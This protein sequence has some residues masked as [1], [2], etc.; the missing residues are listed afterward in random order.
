MAYNPGTSLPEKYARNL[1]ICDYSAGSN[2]GVHACRAE[3]NGAGF[4]MKNAE[5]FVWGITATDVTFGYD[6]KAYVCDYGGGWG[7]SGKGSVI[8]ISEPASLKNPSVD[9]TRKLVADGIGKLETK[10]LLELLKH[11]DM[12][13][14]QHA[15]FELAKR[16]KVG[17]AALTEA[18]NTPGHTLSRVH[19]IWG[20]G[21]LGKTEPA[22]LKTVVAL[23]DDADSRVREQSIKVLSDAKYA[24]AME[25]LLALLKDKNPRVQSFAAIALGKLKCRSDIS[26]LIEILRAND[27]KDAFLRHAAIM[28]LAGS[29]DAAALQSYITDASKAVRLGVLLAYRKMGEARAAEFLRDADP[30]IYAETL[31]AIYEEPIL[32]AM[33]RLAAEINRVVA[34]PD[35]FKGLTPLLYGRILNAA[36][37]YGGADFAPAIARLASIPGIPESVR[38]SALEMLERWDDPTFVDPISGLPRPVAKRAKLAPNAEMREAI[39]KILTENG[40][41]AAKAADMALAFGVELT[42]AM[43]LSFAKNDKRGDAIRISAMQQ[44]LQHKNGELAALLPKIVAE[45]KSNIRAAALGAMLEVEPAQGIAKVREILAGSGPAPKSEVKVVID[46]TADCRWLGDA[47]DGRSVEQRLRG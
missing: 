36:Y 41:V 40:E 34:K 10:A 44:L 14:R 45:G 37:R 11:D 6:G 32:S 9:A 31:R 39:S 20:L 3:E 26:M 1:F 21:Q 38:I 46:K 19:G 30:L 16:G 47:G 8:A 28:G 18:A 22:A 27:D 15:Q 7:L 2:S 25:L 13:V 42:D 12:R 4:V 29:G 24:P 17:L 33:P 5:K 23:L 35:D 43:L